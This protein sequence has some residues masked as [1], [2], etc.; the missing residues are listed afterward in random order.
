MNRNS[1][2]L[3]EIVSDLTR[4]RLAGH[5]T[6]ACVGH[7]SKVDFIY[8]FFTTHRHRHGLIQLM[9]A[10]TNSCPAQ[11]NKREKSQNIMGIRSNS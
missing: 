5:N 10:S 2:F 3:D 9:I 7:K 4:N 6:A 1:S 11:S 8:V